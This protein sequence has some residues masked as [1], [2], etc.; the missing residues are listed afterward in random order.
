[1]RVVQLKAKQ[2]V[3]LAIGV[4]IFFSI[5][6]I[7]MKMLQSPPQKSY[8]SSNFEKLSDALPPPNKQWNALNPIKFAENFLRAP[9]KRE[10]TK[11]DEPFPEKQLGPAAVFK[12]GVIGNY[13]PRD[14]KQYG[15][16]EE[17]KPV[18]VSLDEKD[19]ADR[20]TKEYGFNMVASEK[21]AM[22]RTVPDTRM[23]ECK[24]WHYPEDLPT[25]SVILVFFN[26]GWSTLVR[27]VHSVI[28][29]SPPKLLKEVVLIDDGSD[30]DFLKDKLE[31]YIK[32]FNGLVKIFR[33]SERLGLI[34]ARTKG[35]EH[36][37][38][39]VIVFL[40]A[41]CECNKNWLPPLLTRIRHDRTI[42]AVPIVD[43]IN[44]DTMAYYPV[45]DHHHHRGIFEWGF[46][47][48]EG[49]V[50]QKVLDKRDH[51]SEP[52]ASPTHAG[53]LL[54]MDRNYFF[55]LGGYDPGLKI[56]GGENYELAFKVW[57]CGGSSEWV[58]CSRVGHIYRGPRIGG[59]PKKRMKEPKVPHSYANYLRVVEVWM[60]D[61]FKEYFYA[62][63]PW[64]RGAPFG[65]VSEQL[66]IKKEKNCKSFRWF[67]ENVAYDVYDKFPALPPNV[68]WGEV[69]SRYRL[70]RG[71]CWMGSLKVGTPVRIARCAHHLFQLFRIN[72]KGQLGLGER[73]IM[74][75]NRDTLHIHVCDTQ[76][77]GPWEFD[78]AFGQIK[79][80]HLNKCIGTSKDDKLHLQP[81]DTD[82][83]SQQWEINEIYPWKR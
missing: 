8:S 53:G 2:I 47:Y 20:E 82:N 3:R 41:H 28:N 9:I 12:K 33:N 61:E 78:K 35:A 10:N 43:G 76:P 77:E 60:E 62:R 13:E 14:V 18:V 7:L 15:P 63:E 22:N 83:E 81:C 34:T 32:Q 11:D 38:G 40:D 42:L 24:Y 44:W 59:A 46:L 70:H 25:A 75:Q 51:P 4:G 65:D 67:M 1:M 73:C 71:K 80:T 31:N 72:T 68:A 58:P 79:H 69:K 37:S 21:V 19:D 50:P 52:Y 6:L 64:L 16:G 5:I 55:E 54:A 57:M 27:T 56:W 17:G 48:K 74:E 36:S 45:Y 49:L 39:D 26:E 66:R 23:P 30:Y 29:T